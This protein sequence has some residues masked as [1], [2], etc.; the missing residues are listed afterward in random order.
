MINIKKQHLEAA[1]VV[2]PKHDTRYYFN[3]IL[4]EVTACNSVYLVSTDGCIM[5]VGE[6]DSPDFIGKPVKSLR[7]IIPKTILEQALNGIKTPTIELKQSGEFWQ[8]G[9]VLFTPIDA[10]YPDWRRVNVAPGD[11]NTNPE[12]AQY[13][14]KLLLLA[15]KALA[16]W[17]FNKNKCNAILHQRGNSAGVLV[18]EEDNSAH[19]MIMRIIETPFLECR[20]N[21][22]PRV[23][24]PF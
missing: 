18:H 8:L 20:I 3:G 12:P 11:I 21:A 14:P 19:V 13:D 10:N 24:K 23:V 22:L 9:S 6:V 16:K 1:L 2:A 15:D 5:F 17:I 4:L 7:L